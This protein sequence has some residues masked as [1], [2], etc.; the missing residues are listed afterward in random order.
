MSHFFI[1]VFNMSLTA[2]YVALIVML[3][4]LVL[5]KARLP[6]FFS[7]ILWLVVLFRL[8]F[9]FS[10]ESS[11]SLI[12]GKPAVIS[13]EMMVSESPGIDTGIPILDNTVNHSIESALPRADMTASVNPMGIVIELGALI[14]LVGVLVLLLHS[15]ISYI[16]LKRKLSISTLVKD[17]I[18]ETDQINTP[19]VFGFMKPRIYLPTGLTDRERHFILMHEQT[20]IR[21]LD[22]IVKPVAFLVLVVHWFNPLIWLSYFLMIRDMEMSCDE[23]VMKSADGDFRVGYSKTLLTLA[24]RQSGLLSP[25]SFG[26]SNVKSRVKN[27]LN[28]KKPVF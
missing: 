21:R 28:F 6:V 11:L 3:L 5:K 7:Y 10:F 15:I 2:S 13:P 17:H 26:E 27:I 14:W 4:R 20:H 8:V 22:F 24:S 23:K 12:P 16:R 18:F 1:T 19:F 25:L 9:P